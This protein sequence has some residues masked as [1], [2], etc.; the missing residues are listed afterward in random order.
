MPGELT[1]PPQQQASR[2]AFSLFTSL[3]ANSRVVP[4]ALLDTHAKVYHSTPMP[5]CRASGTET[6]VQHPPLQGTH[7]PSW[8]IKARHEVPHVPQGAEVHPFERT[9]AFFHTF[10]NFPFPPTKTRQN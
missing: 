4:S 7:S 2:K 6:A 9:P 5:L 1:I 8:R 10:S 3:S